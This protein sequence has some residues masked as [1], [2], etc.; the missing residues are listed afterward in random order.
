MHIRQNMKT[1]S[2]AFGVPE[3]TEKIIHQFT[4]TKFALN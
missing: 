4:G 1:Y 2:D 3:W